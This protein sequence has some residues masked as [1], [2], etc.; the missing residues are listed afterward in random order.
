MA[1]F[2]ELGVGTLTLGDTPD[3]FSGEILNGKIGHDY[4]DVGDSRTM[5]D[6]TVRAPGQTRTDSFSADCENDLTGAGL[7][8]FLVSND[9]QKVAFEF[10]PNTG[11]G[12]KWTGFVTCRLPSEIGA[13]EFGAPIAST[14]EL[15]GVGT[16]TFSPSTA[17]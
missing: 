1:A 12:A 14:V 17:P 5:L 9:G 8:S 16:F 7:Y 15:P 4:E 2:T 13:D 3:D 10:V 11:D 6:G